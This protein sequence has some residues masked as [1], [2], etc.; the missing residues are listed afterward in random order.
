VVVG[1]DGVEAEIAR[2]FGGIEDPPPR[3]ALAAEV[4]QGEMDAEFQG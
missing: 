4:D 3:E 2:R 1:G